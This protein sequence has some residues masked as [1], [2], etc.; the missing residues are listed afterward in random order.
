MTTQVKY[1]DL[2]ILLKHINLYFVTSHLPRFGSGL[3][4][5]FLNDEI[6]TQIKNK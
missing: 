4:F 2:K 1:R 6:S 5:Q 3:Q